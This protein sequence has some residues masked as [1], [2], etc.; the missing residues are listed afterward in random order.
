MPSVQ[1]L[2][3]PKD[4]CVVAP[5]INLDCRIAVISRQSGL[6]SNPSLQRRLAQS[7]CPLE[8]RTNSSPHSAQTNSSCDTLLCF[9]ASITLTLKKPP[10]ERRV[11]DYG[12][13][14]RAMRSPLEDHRL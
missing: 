1:R 12:Q 4:H 9:L 14:R 11:E 8:L 3:P 10:R 7:W 6:T 2:W 13:V 5:P